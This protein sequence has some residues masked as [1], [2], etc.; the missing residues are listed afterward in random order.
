VNRTILF[1][2]LHEPG[3][4]HEIA[5]DS[6]AVGKS[7]RISVPNLVAVEAEYYADDGGLL[8]SEA[9]DHLAPVTPLRADFDRRGLVMLKIVYGAV[10]PFN[11]YGFVVRR[12]SGEGVTYPVSSAVGWPET[13]VW[14][15]RGMIPTG[16]PP[17]GWRHELFIANPSRWAELRFKILLYSGG[18]R[19]TV[20]RCL[21]PKESA[22]IPVEP[23]AR[24]LGF[25]QPTDAVG[26]VARN[27]PVVYIMGRNLA[28]DALSFVEHLVTYPRTNFRIPAPAARDHEEDGGAEPLDRVFCYCNGMTL[29]EAL[30]AERE[31]RVG[32]Y[33]TGC[34]DDLRYARRAFGAVR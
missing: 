32:N 14:L 33:C 12:G 28:T 3:L 16:V 31:G 24:E 9:L 34:R 23:L 4:V 18:A 22:F 13:V 26:V 7:R 20:V 30:A 6:Y 5:F 11:V 19:R 2:T 8:A 25:A 21:G 1:G 10:L 27:K 15:N 17:E 29:R